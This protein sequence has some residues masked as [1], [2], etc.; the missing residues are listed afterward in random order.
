MG[1]KTLNG[2]L[3]VPAVLKHRPPFTEKHGGERIER[4]Q[5][6]FERRSCFRTRL[7]PWAGGEQKRSLPV[8]GNANRQFGAR[9]KTSGRFA[10]Q[11]GQQI[12]GAV[13]KRNGVAQ[14][15]NTGLVE[16]QTAEHRTIRP[17]AGLAY[18]ETGGGTGL[19]VTFRQPQSSEAAAGG[20]A[21]VTDLTSNQKLAGRANAFVEG[22]RRCGRVRKT[23]G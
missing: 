21:F 17:Q 3:L 10:S 7:R 23:R 8:R 19:S 16:A 9:P 20:L 11:A 14:G 13:A 12:F 2:Q 18:N 5:R 15:E 1:K 6:G 22:K 4:V